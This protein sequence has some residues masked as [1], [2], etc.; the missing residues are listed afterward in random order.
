M[1]KN[2]KIIALIISLFLILSL[3]ACNKE[4]SSKDEN[5]ETE[6][7]VINDGY[8]I[9]DSYGREYIGKDYAKTVVSLAPSNTEILFALGLD[10]EILGVTSFCNYPEKALEKEK[11]GG[12]SEVNL[13]KIIELDPEVVLL[14]GEGDKDTVDRLNESGI[15]VLGYKMESIDDII[16][17]IES[18]GNLTGKDDEA[19][20]LSLEIITKIDEVVDKVKDLESKKVFYEI[21]YDPIIAVGK[22][23]FINDVI[24]LAKG[25]NIAEVAEGEYPRFDLE[26]LV[27]EDPEVYFVSSDTPEEIIKEIPNRPGFEDIS[28]I[29][30]NNIH[31]LNS[32]ITLRPGP[33]IAEALEAIAK[34]I[35]NEEL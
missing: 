21:A 25:E 17:A 9:K 29:K 20:E 12:F 24:R 35:H 7:I 18:I 5:Q 15:T 28:A 19:E 34:A 14:T 3:V 8:V 31:I 2:K 10:E 1:F 13:E 16:Y 23:S 26:T 11:I 32:D 22:T 27:N 4:G 6:N 30:N 33:R